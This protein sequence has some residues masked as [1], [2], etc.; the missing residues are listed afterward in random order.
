MEMRYRLEVVR[1][2][3]KPDRI[4]PRV[5]VY[6]KFDDYSDEETFSILLDEFGKVLM[7]AMESWC[8]ENNCGHRVEHNIFK[9]LT[10]EELTMFMLRWA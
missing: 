2:H 3:I 7:P 10:E 1:D 4:H 9:F 6:G 8:K 5:C